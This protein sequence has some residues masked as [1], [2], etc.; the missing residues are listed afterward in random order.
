M[1]PEV[2]MRLK[3]VTLDEGTGNAGL[4]CLRIA[5]LK[6]HRQT[7]I[8]PLPGGD[9]GGIFGAALKTLLFVQLSAPGCRN[10]LRLHDLS[11]AGLLCQQLV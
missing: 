11:H 7:E 3:C 9:Q 5:Q 1:E 10:D 8:P 6:P 2:R 4:T